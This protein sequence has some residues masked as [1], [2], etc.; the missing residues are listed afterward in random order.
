MCSS[1]LEMPVSE[2]RGA[3]PRVLSSVAAEGPAPVLS[4]VAPLAHS[5]PEAVG[6]QACEPWNGRRLAI[7]IPL[8]R[9]AASSPRSGRAPNGNFGITSRFSPFV[10]VVHHSFMENSYEEAYLFRRALGRFFAADG[11]TGSS[12]SCGSQAGA[13]SRFSEPS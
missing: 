8:G 5:Y 3:L 6:E 9:M 2:R 12:P 10:R 13:D 7:N 4:L 1:D 11:S